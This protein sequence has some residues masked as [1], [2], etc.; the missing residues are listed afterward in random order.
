MSKSKADIIFL[1]LIGL[2]LTNAFVQSYLYSYELSLNNYLGLI[3][4]VVVLISL[5]IKH[6]TRRLALAI[7]IILGT[8]DVLSFSIGTRTIGFSIGDMSTHLIGFDPIIF[9]VLIAWYLV[10][11]KRINQIIST[12]LYGNTSEIEEERKKQVE[13]YLKKFKELDKPE[14]TKVINDI[15]QYPSEA[16]TAIRMIIS[17]N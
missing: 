10:N 9:L 12:S 3:L 7:L 15:D 4:W 11:H 14:L 2:L 6:K 13:F 5:L 17:G 8:F 1:V 16:Q